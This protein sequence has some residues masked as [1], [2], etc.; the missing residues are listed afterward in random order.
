MIENNILGILAF[1]Q[2]SAIIKIFSFDIKNKK[3]VDSVN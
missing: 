2:N 1:D 3:F